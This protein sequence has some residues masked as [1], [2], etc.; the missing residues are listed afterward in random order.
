MVARSNVLKVFEIR[1]QYATLRADLTARSESYSAIRSGGAERGAEMETQ[2]DDFVN[3]GEFKVNAG[4][5]FGR[6]LFCC[7]T[8]I[9]TLNIANHQ[10]P[11]FPS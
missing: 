2:G 3:V 4:N 5:E 8:A 1:R 11:G 6:T 10:P 9:R 7:P